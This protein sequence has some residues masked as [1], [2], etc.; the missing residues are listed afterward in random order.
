[1]NTNMIQI[2][3]KIKSL[4]KI[5]KIILEKYINNTKIT[6]YVSEKDFLDKF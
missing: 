2:N 5:V 3:T 6:L 4:F 1:M